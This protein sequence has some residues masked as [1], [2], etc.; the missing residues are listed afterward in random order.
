MLSLKEKK[1]VQ[2][3]N[4]DEQE[5]SFLRLHKQKAE[6]INIKKIIGK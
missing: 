5:R 2:R 6:F 3:K 4:D 1:Q